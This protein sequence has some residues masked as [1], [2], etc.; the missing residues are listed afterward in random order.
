MWD[1]ELVWCEFF[2]LVQRISAYD[3][4]INSVSYVNPDIISEAAQKDEQLQT[5]IS[6]GTPLPYLFCVPII[7]KV[8]ITPKI[9]K[10]NPPWYKILQDISKVH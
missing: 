6:Q 10:F 1:H 5:Y 4:I 7:F 9:F 8:S 3:S 2:D